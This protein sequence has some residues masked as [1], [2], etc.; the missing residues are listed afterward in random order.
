MA[1][2]ELVPL[3]EALLDEAARLLADRH[4]RDRAHEPALPARFEEPAGARAAVQA[5]WEEPGARGGAAQRA[6]R[7]VG[8]M[9]GAPQI[10]A[11]WGRSAWVRLGGHAVAET[12]SADLYRDLYAVLSPHWLR[13]GC[14][15]HYAAIPASDRPALDAWFALSFGQ[16]QA[17]ALRSLRGPDPPRPQLDPAITIRRASPDDLEALLQ[18]ADIVA[19]HQAR[20][21]VY[22]VVPPEHR[23][24]WR[25][26]YAELLADPNARIWIAVRDSVVLGFA[27]FTPAEPSD[28]SLYIPDRCCDLLLAG[29][30]ADER[31]KGIGRALTAG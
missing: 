10:D 7:L 9:I 20:S 26:D 28:K 3:T 23:A 27:I 2:L 15:V 25:A 17:Y 6:G 13:L 24:E 29:T 31:S 18:A 21:P 19:V 11:V 12:E 22:A 14:F 1:S 30:R 16:Q 8:F 5:A 4:R